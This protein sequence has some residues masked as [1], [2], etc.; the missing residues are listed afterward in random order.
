MEWR[1]AE[2]KNRFSELVNL[3]LSGDPQLVLRRRDAVVVVA[4]RDYEKLTGK[5][6]SF[7]RFLLG[8][9]P[10]FSGLDLA[11]DESPMRSVKL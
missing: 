1:L 11:R 5:R 3:A 2:A 8:K 4:R 9:G 6:P 7:K 10:S